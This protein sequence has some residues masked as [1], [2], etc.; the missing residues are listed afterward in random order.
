MASLHWNLFKYLCIW[1]SRR[2]PP[3]YLG[4]TKAAWPMWL[5]QPTQLTQKLIAA[6]I[7]WQRVPSD[8]WQGISADLSFNLTLDDNMVAEYGV[9]CEVTVVR[10]RIALDEKW[11]LCHGGREIRPQ[12]PSSPK[13]PSSAP[14]DL[15]SPPEP[16][17][18]YITGLLSAF[19]LLCC[20]VSW[21]SRCQ[22]CSQLKPSCHPQ[23]AQSWEGD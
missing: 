21:Y 15:S 18:S 23:L 19:Y 22:N 16:L 3:P 9:D 2:S 10:W 14:T 12:S 1:F 13:L 4:V 11:W 8:V 5:T 17:K 20:L 7:I 6:I